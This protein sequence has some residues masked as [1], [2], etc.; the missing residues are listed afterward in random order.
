[1]VIKEAQRT[2]SYLNL[3]GYAIDA[4]ICNRLIPATADGAYLKMEAGSDRISSGH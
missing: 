2:Y 3:Y 1:M 4:V